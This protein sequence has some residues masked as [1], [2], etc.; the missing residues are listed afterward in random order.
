MVV[1]T[2]LVA[3]ILELVKAAVELV[4]QIL[5]DARFV[6]RTEP[7]RRNQAQHR[8]AGRFLV[9]LKTQDLPFMKK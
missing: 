6:V 2:F 3:L 1:H 9:E 7:G 4:S 8:A 5:L